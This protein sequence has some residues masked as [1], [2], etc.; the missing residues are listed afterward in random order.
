M[1]NK[2]PASGRSINTTPQS[3]ALIGMPGSGKSTLGVL[4]AKKLGW[5]FIDTDIGIQT[6]A[7]IT[8][9]EIIDDQ[10]Y[11]YLR[12]LEEQTL[13]HVPLP[14]NVIATGGSA[15][16]SA[17]G[18]A[19]IKSLAK[20][21]YLQVSVDELERRIDD[22]GQRGIARRPDQTFEDLY[23]EREPLYRQYADIVID[24]AD[25]STQKIT[26]NL[27]LALKL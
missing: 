7:G 26:A 2:K 16:Y 9:Q 11:L 8:L 4:L 17:A 18:M 6:A 24:C 21:V 3:I 1:A 25:A 10:G 23:L 27:L 15:V 22:Y 12:T 19:H 5:Y 13:L 14:N 20:V